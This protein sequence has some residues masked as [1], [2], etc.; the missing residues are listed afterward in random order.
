MWAAFLGKTG[1]VKFLVQR[2]ANIHAKNKK[3]WTPFL[4]AC[5]KAH[6]DIVKGLIS[7]GVNLDVKTE[8]GWTALSIAY[9]K[10]DKKL[11]PLLLYAAAKSPWARAEVIK[12]RGR[13]KCLP[14]MFAPV[15]SREMAGCLKKG[16]KIL[17]TG[18]WTD[19]NWAMISSPAKGWVKASKIKLL[20]KRDEKRAVINLGKMIKAAKSNRSRSHKAPARSSRAVQEREP[21]EE[22]ISVPV[23]GPNRKSGWH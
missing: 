23:F 9:T 11:I 1:M 14:V 22:P 20:V 7:L 6:Y 4:L 18:V 16:Q 12:V 21:A 19:T 8:D 13:N 3:G 2:G 17:L 10:K 5:S 15:P